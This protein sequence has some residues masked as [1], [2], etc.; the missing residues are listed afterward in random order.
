MAHVIRTDK[1][2]AHDVEILGV[3]LL[4][5]GGKGGISV[6]HAALRMS[7]LQ[8]TDAEGRLKL[9][10]DGNPIPLSGAKLT[11]AAKKYA[12]DHNLAFE[13]INEEKLSSLAEE[14]GAPPNRPPAH[15]VAR[16][17]Y[18]ENFGGKEQ[19]AD[20]AEVRVAGSAPPQQEEEE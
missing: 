16:A 10:K 8:E 3:G 1:N 20:E 7:E 12:E 9:D 13:N 4:G 5:A 11:A 19:P 14:L 18:Q 6:E 17:A 15:E 2:S